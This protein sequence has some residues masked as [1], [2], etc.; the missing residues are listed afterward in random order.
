MAL[1]CPPNK[2]QIHVVFVLFRMVLESYLHEFCDLR[3][4]VK[5]HISIEG[6]VKSIEDMLYFLMLDSYGKATGTKTPV[7]MSY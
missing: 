4:E 5:R 2:S 7:S 3:K 1:L 6:E